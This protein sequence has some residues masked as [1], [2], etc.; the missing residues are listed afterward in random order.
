MSSIGTIVAGIP[1]ST[2]SA[3]FQD[4]TKSITTAPNIIRRLRRNID[5]P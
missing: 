3:S 5:T 4:T 1:S 2:S